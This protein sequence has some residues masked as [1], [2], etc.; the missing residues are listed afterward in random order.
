MFNWGSSFLGI[1]V[2]FVFI[3]CFQVCTRWLVEWSW[4]TASLKRLTSVSNLWTCYLIIN[5]VQLLTSHHHRTGRCVWTGTTK[6]VRI[7]SYG[8]FWN[9]R[10]QIIQLITLTQ[11]INVCNCNIIN[12][13]IIDLYCCFIYSW[14]RSERIQFHH[15]FVHI[16]QGA[17][18]YERLY[19][20][21]FQMVFD[22]VI[23]FVQTFCINVWFFYQNGYS[24]NS[25]DVSNSHYCS[26]LHTLLLVF[27][28]CCSFLWISIL[29]QVIMIGNDHKTPSAKVLELLGDI[30][31][32]SFDLRCLVK[33]EIL[34]LIHMIT[35]LGLHHT[36]SWYLGHTW[37]VRIVTWLWLGPLG[38]ASFGNIA[39]A[40]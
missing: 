38:F 13:L 15:W 29:T 11:L 33:M 14:R 32:F 3:D 18:R 24:A 39:G 26:L 7:H 23:Y 17:I 5:L 31:I 20:S 40:F 21:T 16:L 22:F 6:L 9:L 4:T 25:Y 34:T 19:L 36:Q 12:W 2:W 8:H 10:L 1:E 30:R 27:L 35:I 28:I 37:L